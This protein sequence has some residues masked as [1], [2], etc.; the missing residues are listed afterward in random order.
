MVI[1]VPVVVMR[2]FGPVQH[3]V[4]EVACGPDN[5]SCAHER[6]RLPREGE[7]SNVDEEAA[8][9]QCILPRY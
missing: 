4:C 5:R 9:H 2:R 3:G 6:G 1:T 8:S 7:H